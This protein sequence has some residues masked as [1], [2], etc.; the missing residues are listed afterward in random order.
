[1]RVTCTP[2]GV[3]SRENRVYKH[4]GANDLSTSSALAVTRSHRISTTSISIVQM[5]HESLYQPNSNDSTQALNH[6][7]S[8]RT[9]QRHFAGQKQPECHCRVY[10]TTCN[11]NSAVHKNK[12]HATKGPCNTKK[13]NTITWIFLSLVTNNSGHSNIKEE[14][15][16]YELSYESPVERPEL[17]LSMV[18]EWCWWWVNIVL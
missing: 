15:S 14:K 11:T 7:V 5:L 17:E 13:P 18:N 10:V 9:D 3:C 12:D 6:N 16:S 1:V 4:K 8:H 2:L